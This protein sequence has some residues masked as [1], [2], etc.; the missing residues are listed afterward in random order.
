MPIKFGTSGVRG[1]VAEMTDLECCLYAKAF[2]RY[3][4][5][6]TGA[7]AVALAG[8]YRSS[9]PRIMEAVAYAICG[10]GLRVDYCGY[11]PTPAVLNQGVR[12]DMASIMVTGSHIP[13]DRNGIKFN[14]PW[15]EVL[16]A[17]EKAISA[18]Y[19]SLKAELPG[20]QA[21]FDE[22]G[23]FQTGADR[24]LGEA[25]QAAGED[26]VRRYT[27]F[28]PDTCLAGLKIVFYQHSSV[29]RD[30]LPKILEKLGGK[31]IPV[32]FSEEF[33]PV[34]TE[35]VQEP[36]RLA[37]WVREHKADALVS[38]DGDSDRPLVVD[39][40]GSIVRGDVLG[41]LVSRFLGADSV[42]T[43]VS[44]NTALEKSGWFP[45]VSRTRIGSPFVIESMNEAVGA[46][47]RTVVGYEANGGFL[48]G[49]DISHPDTGAV[50]PALPT[51]AAA[52]PIIVLLSMSAKKG[53]PIS[54]LVDEL[55]PRFTASGL[56]R[57]FPN[58]LAK[59]LVG[60]FEKEGNEFAE[61][62]FSHQFGSVDSMDFTD[63]ARIT[64][65]SE[66][67]IHLRPSGNAPEFRC[68]TESS[69]EEQALSNN[70]IALKI[71]AEMKTR[72]GTA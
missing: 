47:C 48:T 5:Q 38:A 16:K 44:C 67:I 6:R 15:G 56:L 31:V 7:K 26:Y 43:P 28:F 63:G 72:I 19:A 27:E 33:V 11:V 20:D 45:H 12:N 51:R 66:D 23:M 68:Y 25:N 36:E 18:G 3:L 40:Q 71:V 54:G 55:P 17:D 58:E 62:I 9:T 49:T 60:K 50:L 34:D 8:D 22:S 4:K 2:L 46:G 30:L 1:L 32:G 10:E 70:E 69:S 13:D 24:N 35:A 61:S 57:E 29:G 42:S 39:E 14:M 53:R 64:F 21:V 37:G 52:L 59:A 65:S 41:I